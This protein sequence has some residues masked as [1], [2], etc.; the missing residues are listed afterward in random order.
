[1][2]YAERI[3]R[4]GSETAFEVLAKAK[5]LEAQGH[6]IVHMEIGEP[7]FTTP[8][9]IID[10]GVKALYEGHTHYTGSA[11]DF[12][13]RT[14]YADYLNTRYGTKL[15]GE[16]IVIT[17]GAK[18]V[19]FLSALAIINPGDEVI[20]PDPG[21]P[22]YRSVVNFL[23]AEHKPYHLLEEN[24]FRFDADEVKSLVTNKTRLMILNTPH[25]PTGGVLTREDLEL[26]IDLAVKHDFWV[27]S[28][29]IYSRI[30]YGR[31]HASVMQFPEAFDRII[32]LDGHSKTYAMTGW[33]LGY[34]AINKE[35]AG[36]MTTLM[37]NANSCTAAFTQIAGVEALHGD[38]SAV[39][40]MVKEFEARR[41]V[42]VKGMNALPGVTCHNPEGAFY[43][44]PN[45]K[46]YGRK[47]SELQQLFLDG[48]VAALAGTAFGP[49]GEGYMRFSYATSQDNIREGLSRVAKVL[50]NLK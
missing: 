42:I 19:L 22:I 15:D 13:N 27:L 34:A 41:N 18:P 8:K 49:A 6:S 23:E 48:G 38:Q 9:N 25:N 14:S 2:K 32:L 45:F 33:R 40:A 16:N 28:D 7:D 46:S 4:L 10:A 44:F 12:K 11:G 31:E 5:K 30:L 43:V 35:L 29:E 36:Y 39:E 47:S 24:D 20:Y 1:L 50:A 17:P 21:Y 37:T 3:S 26:V